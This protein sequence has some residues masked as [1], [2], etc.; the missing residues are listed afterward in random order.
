MISTTYSTDTADAIVSLL[1]DAASNDLD[2][3]KTVLVDDWGVSATP[4][5][6]EPSSGLLNG[7][8]EET[9]DA[10][11]QYTTHKTRKKSAHSLPRYSHSHK[12]MH[13]DS[14]STS[15]S[16]IGNHDN[17]SSG[18]EGKIGI[19]TH[20]KG[21]KNIYTHTPSHSSSQLPS[22]SDHHLSTDTETD[23]Y[24]KASTGTSTGGTGFLRTHGAA[25]SHALRHSPSFTSVTS[26]GN[27]SDALNSRR[28][29]SLPP[30]HTP[31][32]AR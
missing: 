8:D 16:G 27:I 32:T 21:S 3:C 26:V 6:Q 23:M 11:T 25:P 18:N 19:Y 13:K 15:S 7:S 1:T 12:D 9:S 20:K 5:I 29:R 31:P 17:H 2:E 22:P 4:M 14:I 10:L 28:L 24:R 30:A